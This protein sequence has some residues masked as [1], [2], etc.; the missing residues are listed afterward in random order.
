MKDVVKKIHSWMERNL[1]EP[2]LKAEM[3]RAE[4]SEKSNGLSRG[5]QY[6]A[7]VGLVV[8]VCWVVASAVK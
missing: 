2:F 5:V 7:A 3:A 6:T 8:L 4:P 1:E